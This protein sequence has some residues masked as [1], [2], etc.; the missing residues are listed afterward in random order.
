[1]VMPI[2]TPQAGQIGGRSSSA[3]ALF[4]VFHAVSLAREEIPIRHVEL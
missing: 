1:M 4:P 3:F 2:V